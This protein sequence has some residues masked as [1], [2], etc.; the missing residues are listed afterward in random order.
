MRVV[1]CDANLTSYTGHFATQCRALSAEF[2]A[3][4]FE[5]TVLAN[6]RIEEAVA[7]ELKAVGFFSE[8][9]YEKTSDD[10][11]CWWL[12]SFFDVSR[13]LAADFD[14][15]GQLTSEDLVYYDTA[16]PAPVMALIEWAQ[17]KFSPES[18]PNIA[19]NF[20]EHSDVVAKKSASGQLE[21]DVQSYNPFLYRYA[22]LAVD[23][24]YEHC[25]HWVSTDVSLAEIYSHV[26]N[27]PVTCLPTPYVAATSPRSRAGAREWT[28]GFLGAQR[29]SKNFHLVPDVLER[30]LSRRADVRIVIQNSW[31]AMEEVAVR[32]RGQA[33]ADPRIELIGEALD[34]PAW[35]QLLDRCDLLV[36]AYDRGK[37]GNAPSG[38]V[39]EG[40]ANGI[41]L[42]VTGGTAFERSAREYGFPAVAIGELEPASIAGAIEA[43]LSDYEEL[44]RRAQAAS[45]LWGAR[46]GPL[47]TV[48]ALL[49]KVRQARAN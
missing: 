36:A 42:V 14:K 24:R 32:V 19:M 34:E 28:V 45:G 44:A 3:L 5:T 41:P 10:P 26:L 20:I 8:S 48:Q 4:G 16:T 1:Y 22:S 47:R 11:L 23:P 38:I 49:E 15:A 33:A 43:A 12:K 29:P 17:K 31:S 7:D 40:L 39:F 46:N 18:C 21:L 27:R 30:L 2:R 35:A 6:R 9:P 25:F 37:Y 13:I